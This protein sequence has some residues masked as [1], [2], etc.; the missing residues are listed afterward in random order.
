[1]DLHLAEN[2]GLEMDKS[3]ER[4]HSSIN[5]TFSS[6]LPLRHILALKSHSE[7]VIAH[8]ENLMG[9]LFACEYVK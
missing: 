2:I 5:L 4:P 9:C 7:S 6:D 8:G 1:M 3:P